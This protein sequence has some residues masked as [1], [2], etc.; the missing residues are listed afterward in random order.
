MRKG[1]DAVERKDDKAAEEFTQ[2]AKWYSQAGQSYPQDD[3]K[4]VCEY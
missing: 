3:E 4:H 2:A 1:L